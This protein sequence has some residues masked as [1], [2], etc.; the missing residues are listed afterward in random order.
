MQ[1]NASAMGQVGRLGVNSEPRSLQAEGHVPITNLRVWIGFPVLAALSACGGV[2]EQPADK[3]STA[4]SSKSAWSESATV[5]R[6][7]SAKD[8]GGQRSK[9]STNQFPCGSGAPSPVLPRGELGSAAPPV[10][11]VVDLM[12]VPVSPVR[13]ARYEIHA[14]MSYSYGFAVQDYDCDSRPDVSF[15]D[16]EVHFRDLLRSSDKGAIGYIH[17]NG[18][19]LERIASNETY[20]ELPP[21]PEEIVLFE[22]HLSV[23]VN[24]DGRPDVVGVLNSHGA[25]V[26]YLNPGV[27]GV[28]WDRQYLSVETPGAVNIAEGD[29]D[30]DGDADLVVAM[31][32]QPSTSPD[33]GVRGLV[34]LENPGQEPGQWWQH[35]VEGSADLVE[36]RNLSAADVDGDG[37]LDIV[38]GDASTGLLS[39]FKRVAGGGWERRDI[40]NVT[41]IHGHFGTTMDIDRDGHMDILQPVYQGI[42][43]VRNRGRGEGW[44]VIP[45]ARFEHEIVQIVVS[46]VGLGDLDLDGKSDI[47]FS[48]LTLSESPLR[49]RRGGVYWLRQNEGAWDAFRI[50]FEENATVG[51]SLLDYDG[52]GDVDV[53]SNSEYQRN[54]VTLWI[55][56]GRG[57]T[58]GGPS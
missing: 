57:P 49:V 43:W 50:L 21:P 39:W 42:V 58:A 13:F 6:A 9:V 34:W 18:G 48:I 32:V 17:W 2:D 31:R 33:P 37:A 29:L 25:V 35:P 15:F 30:T 38:V 7:P 5:S 1:Q 47:V 41:T 23:D 28:A 12:T 19:S 8:S 3:V 45:I 52:D 55:N 26:A 56:Q 4:A 54:A 46:D 27:R 22:R 16:S 10:A 53:L 14:G 40:A 36:P 44:D 11:R 24:G 51:L 20:P